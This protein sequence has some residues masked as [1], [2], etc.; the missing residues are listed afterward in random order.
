MGNHILLDKELRKDISEVYA[1]MNIA[2]NHTYLLTQLTFVIKTTALDQV[3][4]EKVFQKQK[5]NLA[6]KHTN[7]ILEI[8]PLIEEITNSYKQKR[9]FFSCLRRNKN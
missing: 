1:L 4:F 5:D 2:N 3:N 9:S 8:E 7:L 6:E